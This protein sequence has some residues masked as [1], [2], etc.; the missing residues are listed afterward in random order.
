[1]AALESHVL[2]PGLRHSIAGGEWSDSDAEFDPI[3]DMARVSSAKHADQVYADLHRGAFMVQSIG[4]NTQVLKVIANADP[5]LNYIPQSLINFAMRNVCGVF[6][7]LVESKAR[8]L[9]DEYKQLIAEK[10]DFYEQVRAKCAVSLN[11]KGPAL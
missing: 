3:G 2:S 11:K 4:P 8:D 1:M 6:L 10:A 7:N 9:T 5:K